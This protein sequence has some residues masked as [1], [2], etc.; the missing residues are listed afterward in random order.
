MGL[1][2]IRN[3]EFL[4]CDN[5]YKK[6][7]DKGIRNCIRLEWSYSNLAKYWILNSLYHFSA[8]FGTQCWSG[9]SKPGEWPIPN[10]SSWIFQVPVIWQKVPGIRFCSK[11]RTAHIKCR[12]FYLPCPSFLNVIKN[13]F[14]SSSN[15][16]KICIYPKYSKHWLKM[17]QSISIFF[18]DTGFADS[19]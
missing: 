3:N 8:I 6:L 11:L 4:E 17:C 12:L 10:K 2:L 9:R 18:I 5:L 19:N 13:C 14:K 1:T 16:S 15:K 7:L